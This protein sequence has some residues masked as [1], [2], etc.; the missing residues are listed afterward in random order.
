MMIRYALLLHSQSPAAYATIRNSGIM[1]LPGETTLR[2]YTNAIH[3]E[4]GINPEV[5]EE[6]RK[7]A[8]KLKDNQ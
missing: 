5:L 2:A 7:A 1:K 6:V 4:A 3:P 8:A